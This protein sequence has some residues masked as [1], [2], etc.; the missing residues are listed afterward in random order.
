MANKRHV[1]G[2]RSPAPPGHFPGNLGSQQAD[3]YWVSIQDIAAV[4]FQILQ[5]GTGQGP[6]GGFPPGPPPNL[7]EFIQ[8][9]VAAELLA[10]DNITL[11]YDDSAGTITISSTGGTQQIAYV[12]DDTIYFPLVDGD[13]EPILDGDGDVIYVPFTPTGGGASGPDIL[14][15]A[16]IGY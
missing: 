9:T 15:R 7:T 8:D 5:G 16:F 1:R 14:A 6:G 11:V 2:I 13:H 12:D 3:P 10:G 4:I